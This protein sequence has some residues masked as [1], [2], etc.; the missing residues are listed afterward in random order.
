M[1]EEDAPMEED[2]NERIRF[3]K[4]ESPIDRFQNNPY[5]CINEV[6]TWFQLDDL[7]DNLQQWL[8]IALINDQSAY[9]EGSAREDVMDFCDELQLLMEA[10]HVINENHKPV[11]AK[12]WLEKLPVKLREE[13]KKY[14]QPVM[15]T[16]EQKAD[17]QI[18]IKDFCDTFSLSYVRRELWD[19]MDSVVFYERNGNT[20]R[21]EPQAVYKCLL[22]L[23][24]AAYVI[25]HS[26]I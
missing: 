6:F 5:G 24:E 22:A 17:P 9:D 11:K 4:R 16:E 13:L 19:L 2:E 23:V 26:Y 8:H 10:L 15:L 21:S 12:K 7:G 18:I 20:Q 25:Y 14:N 3:Q 1:K